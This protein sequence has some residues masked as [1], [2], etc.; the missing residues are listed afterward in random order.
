MKIHHKRRLLVF[1]LLLISLIIT[2]TSFAYW[3]ESVN[4]SSA[5]MVGSFRI[6]TADSVAT[7][8]VI[9]PDDIHSYGYLVPEN[10]IN[11]SH[12]RAVAEIP[13]RF[14]IQWLEEN[15]LSQ[16]DGEEFYGNISEFITYDIYI[17]GS[18]D[19]LNKSIYDSV[20]DLINI[21]ENQLNPEQI[22]L[23]DES[24]ISL[25]YHVTLDE[26][27]S[28]ETY[29]LI[30][31]ATIVFYFNFEVR[32]SLYDIN[33]DFTNMTIPDLFAADPKSLDM[34]KWILDEGTS[35]TNASG[36]TRIYFPMTMDEYTIT[37]YAKIHD[38][39]VGG[40][41]IFFD[42]YL[43]P[44]NEGLDYGYILQYDRGYAGG[45]LI[46]RPRQNGSEGN[47]IWS[48]TSGI[49]RLIPSKADDPEWWAET[50]KITINVSNIDTQTRQAE[51]YIDDV[52][53]GY[54]TYENQVEDQDLVTGFRGWNQSGTEF[55]SLRVD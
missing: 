27:Q 16:I 49:D 30:S 45:A 48:Y 17:E 35:L 2:G 15:V 4:G 8:F 22:K 10:Q 51:F 52:F 34:D 37:S 28:V 21:E 23:N 14:H 25:I 44:T 13:L 20:Y 3:F 50:H 31:R 7:E 41:G 9:S 19:I 32:L 33:L 39:D 53:L 54:F 40:F 11:N 38:G 55:Y 26:P 6:G 42:T 43:D 29:E 18:N 36:E 1:I 24:G 47:P 46:V 5:E 12:E